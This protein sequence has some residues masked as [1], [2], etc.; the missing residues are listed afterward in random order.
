MRYLFIAS[1]LLALSCNQARERTDTTNYQVITEKCYV[2]RQHPIQDSAVNVKKDSIVQFLNGRGF[3]AKFIEKDSLMFRRANGL[4]VEIIL[5]D[6]QSAWE[7][8]A[9]IV[10][11]P[12]QNP[13]FVNLHKGTAQVEHY[14]EGK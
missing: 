12:Q 10:F 3:A 4:Q 6:A 1:A 5:P 7:S 14:A 11:D 9:I 8:N 2:L 13:F